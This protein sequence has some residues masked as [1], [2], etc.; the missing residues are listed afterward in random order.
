MIIFNHL[1]EKIRCNFV[2]FFQASKE[3][4]L[5][6]IAEAECIHLSTNVSWKLSAIVLSPGEMVC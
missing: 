5:S 2:I 6:Q 3:A 4:V 1:F